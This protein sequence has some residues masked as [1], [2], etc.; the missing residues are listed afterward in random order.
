MDIHYE[1]A[2]RLYAAMEAQG[3]TETVDEMPVVVYRGSVT[4]MY[5][6]VRPALSM[7]DYARLFRGLKACGSLTLLQKGARSTDTVYALHHPPTREQWIAYER[8]PLTQRMNEGKLKEQVAELR[9]EVEKQRTLILH[10]ASAVG[11]A[12]PQDELPEPSEVPTT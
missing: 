3:H 1:K 4:K 9:E 8:S 11:V 2:V 6:K 10:L 12:L 5:Q 7:T